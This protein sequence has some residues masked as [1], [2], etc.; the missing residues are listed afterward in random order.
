MHSDFL[1]GLRPDQGKQITTVVVGCG[2]VGCCAIASALYLTRG[3]KVFAVDGVEERLQEAAKIGAIPLNLNDGVENLVARVQAETSGRGA[4][5][6]L[7]LVGSN[8]ALDVS[9]QVIR[10]FGKVSSIGVHTN[11]ITIPAA[12]FYGKN[13]T[14]AMGRCPVSGIFKESLVA[15]EAVHGSLS[16]LTGRTMPL[17]QAPEAYRIFEQR[18]VSKAR[19]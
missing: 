6:A 4:D 15:L 18:K 9:L 8:D 10:P 17:E 3:G 13:S 1:S 5:V 19:F 14:I 12:R 7:E 11:D 2:P 16:F